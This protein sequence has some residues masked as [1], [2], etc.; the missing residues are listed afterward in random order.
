MAEPA[1]PGTR[2]AALVGRLSALAAVAR[3]AGVGQ[4]VLREPATLAWLLEARVHVPQTLESACLDVVVDLSG[5]EPVLRV[6]CNAIEAP[7]LRDFCERPR[8]F[9]SGA[10]L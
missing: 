2:E 9:S 5:H 6:V 7:R 8:L 10:W 3:E 1:R 4:L